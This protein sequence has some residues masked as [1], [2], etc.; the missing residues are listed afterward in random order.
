[1]SDVPAT[2]AVDAGATTPVPP[3]KVTLT[4]PK[5]GD[6]TKFAL[7]MNFPDEADPTKTKQFLYCLPCLN[8][9]L[10]S[11][12]KEKAIQTLD[13]KVEE[14][15]SADAPPADPAL[16]GIRKV[17]PGLVPGDVTP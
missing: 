16:A 7:F 9:V 8:E 6:V 14:A 4:C 2:P 11:L 17:I 3:Q 12:Q 13:I 5:H 1:M 15:V 10:L